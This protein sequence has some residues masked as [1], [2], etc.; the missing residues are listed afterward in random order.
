VYTAGMRRRDLWFYIA[1]VLFVTIVVIA[2]DR[3]GH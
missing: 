3:F 2:V 1:V